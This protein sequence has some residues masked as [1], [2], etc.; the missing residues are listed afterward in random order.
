MSQATV[1]VPITLIKTEYLSEQEVRTL[2][3]EALLQVFQKDQQIFELKRSRGKID[4]LMLKLLDL[5]IAENY[6]TLMSELRAM[7]E[8]L[9]EQRA[10]QAAARRMH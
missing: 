5:Y 10:A 7:A 6:S 2:L 3:D 1:Q 4:R 9:Q 8:Y